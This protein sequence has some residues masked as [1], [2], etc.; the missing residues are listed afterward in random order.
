M[1]DG[2]LSPQ[3]SLR[4]HWPTLAIAAITI[5]SA[6]LRLLPLRE[7]LWIDELHTA[8]CA[9]AALG[10]VGEYAAIGNQSP[11]FFWLEWLLVRVLGPSEWSLRLPS[12]IVGSL[13]PLALYML[14]R[15]WT[16]AGVGLVAAVLVAI[17]PLAIFYATEARPYALVQ[18]LSVIHVGLAAELFAR[19][20][21]ALRIGWISLA[22]VIFHLHYTAGLLIA[23]EVVAYGIV[24][25]L[26][27]LEV[28][29]GWRFAL[30][31]LL[32]VAALCLPAAGILSA[33]FA[34]RTNWAEF[35]AQSDIWEALLW[36]PTAV[37]GFYV[38]GAM[39]SGRRATIPALLTL[40]WAAVP[41]GLTWLATEIDFVRLFYPRY[42][43]I[44]QPAAA[45]LAAWC[46]ELAP[47]NWAKWTYAALLL[48][49]LA[50]TGGVFQR[51][52]SEGRTITPR[53][54]DW[55]G[56]VAWLNE[57]HA[58]H[59]FPVFVA[60]GL[61]EVKEMGQPQNVRLADYL[62]LPVTSLYPL[63]ADR[64]EI[65]PLVLSREGRLDQ[66]I[67][68]LILH[69]GGAWLVV[70]GSKDAAQQTSAA[71]AGRLSQL[72]LAGDKTAWRIGA[73]W[74][75]GRVHVLSIE[76]AHP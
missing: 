56:A 72:Q 12:F 29:Y 50:L 1:P 49:A 42:L 21:R 68:M 20:T 60:S 17:D 73:E 33:I 41:V 13:L 30:L 26:R 3:E 32:I 43:I 10:E 54:E 34:R 76:A 75:G 57:Q 15:R 16:I 66:T 70:R 65:A 35:V 2:A 23:A 28:A 59:P 47:W 62:L 74:S 48:V 25:A 4:R 5:A 55:R 7:S 71:I 51:L 63:E 18:L 44:V 52:A 14:A 53:N 67:E 39:I 9:L 38:L 8:W 36:W 11:L 24:L 27:P 37:G 6:A 69:R 40:C 31:D 58:Y 46:I 19:P 61:I 45:L 22:A 64:N